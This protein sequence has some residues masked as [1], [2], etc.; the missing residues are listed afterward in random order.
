MGVSGTLHPQGQLTALDS[1][2]AAHGDIEA[3]S[4]AQEAQADMVGAGVGQAGCV[5]LRGGCCVSRTAS[6]LVFLLSFIIL[7]HWLASASQTSLPYSSRGLT[8]DSQT[9]SLARTGIRFVVEEGPHGFGPVGGVGDH[10]VL[11]VVSPREV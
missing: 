6:A 5:E 4:A 8:E 11:D 9:R 2:Y 7:R 1:F 10:I 3:R